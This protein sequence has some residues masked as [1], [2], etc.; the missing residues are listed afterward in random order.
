MAVDA[1][2]EGR[3][4]DEKRNINDEQLKFSHEKFILH[5]IPT[6][7]LAPLFSFYIINELSFLLR[8]FT[9]IK[10][11]GKGNFEASAYLWRKKTQMGEL[12]IVEQ[13]NILRITFAEKK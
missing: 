1:P 2:R 11:K 5:L 12:S 13:T 7:S 10:R 8:H 9:I 3:L 4:K 6:A